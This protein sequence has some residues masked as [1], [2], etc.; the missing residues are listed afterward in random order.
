MKM[1]EAA[2]TWTEPARDLPVYGHFDVIVIGGGPAGFG[3]AVAAARQGARTLVVERFPFFGG[4]ATASLMANINGYRNQVEPDGLQTTKGIG[5][6]VILRMKEIGGLG[7]DGHGKPAY[8]QKERT[9]T[10]GDLSFGYAI[11]PEKYK[12]TMLKM[13]VES[14]AQ[15]LFHTTF[16][17]TI[18]DG[19][20]VAGV[21]LESKAGRRAAFAKVVVDASG[22]ADVAF[23]AG[24]PYW[25]TVHDEAKRLP[26]VLM[27]KVAGY[28]NAE[29]V[30]GAEVDGA[31]V[32]WGPSAGKIDSLSIDELTAA[33]IETRLAVYDHLEA[34]KEKT[35]DLEGARIIETPV[36]L[37]RRQTRFIQG[38]YKIVL[39]D[40]LNAAK[41]EDS[42][43]MAS[44]PIIE[45]FGYRRYLEHEGYEIPYGVMLPQEVDGLLVVG[46]C[47]SSDQPA[48]ESW[49]SMGP[50]MVLGQAAG[51]A[52]AL[53]A[54]HGVAPRNVDIV[55]LQS[56]LIE[57]GSEIGQGR[58]DGT[59]HLAV[60]KAKQLA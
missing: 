8:V 46:R 11:D 40:V 27:Y 7:I 20:R 22:D 21:V 37:G 4:S 9:H 45:Y 43:A 29:K 47:M 23:S 14:G 12:F 53:A 39:D 13:V 51:T 16:S 57:Q 60:M 6:E 50:C 26:D 3:S 34:H 33:E 2:E 5:E 56:S 58:H 35:P 41:F 38:M 36:S 49:R 31:M 52:A 55:E 10:K 15:I 59:E 18:M 24:V 48:F 44:K 30:H 32:L 42:I 1:T 28:Q 25:Q 54:K 19:N 17:R